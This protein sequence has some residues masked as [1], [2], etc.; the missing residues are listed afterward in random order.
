MWRGV[1]GKE[2]V[3]EQANEVAQK[4]VFTGILIVYFQGDF[5]T[6]AMLWRRQIEKRRYRAVTL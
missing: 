1:F 5:G 4:A 3:S 2:L 6:G